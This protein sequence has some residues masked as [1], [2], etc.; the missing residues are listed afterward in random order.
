MIMSKVA[1]KQGFTFS[2]EDTFSEKPRGK[3][4][5]IDP[6][7]TSRFRVKLSSLYSGCN[8]LTTYSSKVAVFQKITD[9]VEPIK[10][11]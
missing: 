7:P 1:K 4:V 9:K 6:P 2:L 3:R 11:V 5:Q 10:T 8:A